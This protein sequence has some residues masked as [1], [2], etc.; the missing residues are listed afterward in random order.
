M[1]AQ[2]ELLE[3][4]RGDKRYVRRDRQ[5]EFTTEQEN[6]GRS[7]IQDRRRAAKTVAKKG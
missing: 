6:V 2:R 7:L 1:P 5:G 4:R 3:P